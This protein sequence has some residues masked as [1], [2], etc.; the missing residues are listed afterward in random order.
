MLMLEAN[1]GGR[2][3]IISLFEKSCLRSVQS[4]CCDGYASS[5][6]E[7]VSEKTCEYCQCP[8]GQ[9]CYNWKAVIVKKDTK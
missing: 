2:S 3:E 6:K 9:C 5:N 4:L 7:M 1:Y 8:L